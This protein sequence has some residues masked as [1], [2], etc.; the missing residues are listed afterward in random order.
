[1]S[2][3]KKEPLYFIAILPPAKI[4]AEIE[5]LKKEIKDKFQVK[6]ALKLPAHITLQ[7][8]FRMPPTRETILIK[9]LQGLCKERKSFKAHLDGFD[10]FS[11]HVIFIKINEHDPFISLSKELQELMLNFIDLKSHEI[12][13][14]MHPHI[15][16]ATRDLNRTIFPKVWN[17]FKDRDYKASF[18]VKDL[19]LLKH[20]GKTWDI[21]KKITFAD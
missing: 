18:E 1:M 7:I 21:I 16:I 10:K 3:P 20:N 19:H 17:E 13:S 2:Q 14:K 15:T 8:P 4:R 9:K 11:K 6:H 12:A 5:T